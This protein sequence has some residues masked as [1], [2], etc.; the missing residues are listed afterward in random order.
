M[1][2]A[3]PDFSGPGLADRRRRRRAPAWLARGG[4]GRLVVWAGL[5]RAG[6]VLDRVR[7][8][9]RCTDLRMADAVRRAGPAGISRAVPRLRFCD[10][11]PDLDQG[12]LAGD[13]ACRKPDGKRMAA[14]SCTHRLSMERV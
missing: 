1:A 8:P 14:R 12:W 2:R 6:T 11:A 9:G 3:V 5:F 4:G 10:G 7:V 13:R